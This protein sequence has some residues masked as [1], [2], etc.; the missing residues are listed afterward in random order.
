VKAGVYAWRL[1]LSLVA[2][3]ALAFAFPNYN[4]PLLGWVSLAGLILAVAGARLREAALCGFLYGGT[5]SAFSLPWIYTVLRQYGPLPVW[6]AAGVFLLAVVQQALLYVLFA[7]VLTWAFARNAR[8]S[9]LLAPFLWVAVELLR[10]RLPSIGFGWNLLGYTAAHSLAL[11]QI[12][13]V[14]GIYGLSLLVAAY[15]AL[16]G[17]AALAVWRLGRD[18]ALR[19]R[20]V[21]L[22][23]A[24]STVL[25]VVAAGGGYLVP[26]GQPTATAHLVQTNLAQSMEYP[27]NWD[28][29]HAGDMSQLDEISIAAAQRRPGLIV[30]PE[31]PAPF[32]FQDT[33]F[34]KRAQ[35][36][37]REAN[38]DF[39]LGVIGWKADKGAPANAI[40]S[41]YNSAVLL[42]PDGRQEF[43]YDKM[44]LV[45]FTEYVPWRNFLWFAKDLT[46]LVGDFHRGA[47]HS[48]GTFPGGRF[49]VFICYEAVFPD[50]VREFSRNGAGLL[51][52]ISNDGWFGRSSAPAQHLEMSRVRAVENRRWLLRDTNNGFTAAIDP[53]GRVVASMPPDVRGELDAPYAIRQELTVYTRFGDW[54]A[55]L[56]V[57]FSAALLVACGG[58]RA[59]PGG[60]H[61]RE[62]AGK[63]GQQNQNQKVRRA[64]NSKVRQGSAT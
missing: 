3:L 14:T 39:L 11:V 44:H 54:I 16:L 13:A 1:A 55:W 15:N 53:Y 41:P 21:K 23:L 7:V 31:V 63:E 37:A 34:A 30:W 32:S 51:I 17:A 2:G 35:R 5:F 19:S 29:V 10:T 38:S 52:N 47:E 28:A 24:G 46:A 60:K 25:V 22:L 4:V 6:Q 20:E 27:D 8:F 26:T 12:T 48:V 58:G 62:A 33:A 50:E 64:K 42:G 9:L 40:K 45:P 61:L 59:K 56:S 49:G 18:R 57:V 43:Q 36:I